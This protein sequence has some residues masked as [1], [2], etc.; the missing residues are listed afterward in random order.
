M[1]IS[2]LL[3]GD[4]DATASQTTLWVARSYPARTQEEPI[5]IL[6]HQVPSTFIA[7]SSDKNQCPASPSRLTYWFFRNLET[8]RS[9]LRFVFSFFLFLLSKVSKINIIQL[10]NIKTVL[11]FKMYIFT[12]HPNLML[13]INTG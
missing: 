4:A 12:N 11:V 7:R 13:N 1:F 6:N 8:R 9:I 3:Q 2:N 10:C 5:V